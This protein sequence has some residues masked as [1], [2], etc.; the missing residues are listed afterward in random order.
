MVIR[1]LNGK[2]PTN[3]VLTITGSDLN[4]ATTTDAGVVKVDGTTINVT[5]GVI[6]ANVS[7]TLQRVEFTPTVANWWSNRFLRTYKLGYVKSLSL[8]INLLSGNQ[9]AANTDA[10][11]LTLPADMRPVH[12]IYTTAFDNTGRQFSVTV[13]S[14]GNLNINPGSTAA[15]LNGEILNFNITFLGATL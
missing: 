3:G 2:E 13:F 5:N 6:S 4:N 1:K 12:T 8:N 9:L 10:T 15:V 14:S 7:P 11:I